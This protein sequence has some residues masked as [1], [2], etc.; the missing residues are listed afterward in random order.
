M[1]TDHMARILVVEDHLD[2]ATILT[3]LLQRSG[4]SVCTAGTVQDALAAAG[5]DVP[6]ELV[7]SD[8]GLPD[9]TGY[10][11]MRQLRE[12]HPLPGIALSGYAQSE[13]VRRAI[14]A[15]FSRH[16]TK[17]IDF[18]K[19]KRVIDELLNQSITAS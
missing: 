10:D 1:K 19:L 17:P 11:L 6:F 4:Y 12:R 16:L 18:E 3:R 2:S 14:D 8:L 5:E 13:N 9:G 7:I 15:G